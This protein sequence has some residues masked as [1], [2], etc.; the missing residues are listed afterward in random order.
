MFYHILF[1]FLVVFDPKALCC[2]RCDKESDKRL[3][4]LRGFLADQYEDLQEYAKTNAHLTRLFEAAL[5]PFSNRKIDKIAILQ[6]A[7]EFKKTVDSIENSGVLGHLLVRTLDVRFEKLKTKFGD[8]LAQFLSERFC[9]NTIGSNTCGLME[10]TLIDCESCDPEKL[11]CI[12]GHGQCKEKVTKCPLCICSQENN[13]CQDIQKGKSCTPCEGYT[14][15]LNEVLHCGVRQT[16]VVQDEDLMFDCHL[17]WHAKVEETLEYVFKRVGQTRSKILKVTED[18][19]LMKKNMY[20][21]DAGNYSCTAQLKSSIPVSTIL[22]DVKVVPRQGG[23]QH[24]TRPTLP[25]IT[26]IVAPPAP[27]YASKEDHL[28]LAAIITA[29]VCGALIIIIIACLCVRKLRKRRPEE[30]A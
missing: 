26:H 22:Y 20:Y 21:S 6:M 19:L 2:L 4:N 3:R 5:E 18:P 28:I 8:I 9:P 13:K 14:S 1:Y 24:R 11:S 12:G 29:S 16:E 30:V 15:C 10:Q 7:G 25:P 23:E 27:V 17:P